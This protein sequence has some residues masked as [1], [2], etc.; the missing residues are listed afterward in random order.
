MHLKMVSINENV[1]KELRNAVQI[2][3]DPN[4]LNLVLMW[5]TFLEDRFAKIDEW[6]KAWTKNSIGLAQKEVKSAL[7]KYEK[8]F[9]EREN[10][11]EQAQKVAKTGKGSKGNGKATASYAEE[12]KKKRKTLSTK[13]AQQGKEMR[14]HR[15]E[16]R[17]LKATQKASTRKWKKPQREAHQVKI[18]VKKEDIE[19]AERAY[20]VTQRAI[21]ELYS[22]SVK[23]IITNLKKDQ[24]RLLNFERK[25]STLKMPRL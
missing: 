20:G 24:E 3:G 19:D 25:V 2:T 11:E 17:T 10:A 7:V 13:L 8:M 4:V 12:Q 9:R 1:Q 23:M 21:H 5:D 6:A 18:N 15:E 22:Y 14:A 16:L